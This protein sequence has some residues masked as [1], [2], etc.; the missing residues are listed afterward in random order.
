MSGQVSGVA[1]ATMAGGAVLVVAGVKGWSIPKAVQNIVAGKPPATGNF[2][3]ISGT[4][5]GALGTLPPGTA[6]YPGVPGGTA[7]GNRAQNQALAK[8][9]ASG[10]HP[11][12]L[13]G[14][15]WAD[16]VTLWDG[17]SG[18]SQTADTRQTHLDPASSDGFA[19]GIPQARPYSKMPRAGWPPDKGG[20]ADPSAQISWGIDYIASTYGNP[21]AA[22]A[23]K[24][25]TGGK[26]Y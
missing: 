21:S 13:A 26:G 1:L 2:Y 7:G 4:P 15:Q 8:L 18:W 23:F 17:E 11:D 9:M 6:V 12:W 16:W 24:N 14:Q 25:S 5:Q 10:S 19:Y 3:P 22:L 20:N